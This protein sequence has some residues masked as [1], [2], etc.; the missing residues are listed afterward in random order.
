MRKIKHIARKSKQGH[1]APPT[2]HQ[3]VQHAPPAHAAPQAPTA[4]MPPVKPPEPVFGAHAVTAPPEVSLQLGDGANLLFGMRPVWDAGDADS[5]P[6]FQPPTQ[7]TKQF[8]ATIPVDPAAAW[9]LPTVSL[10]TDVAD[11]LDAIRNCKVLPVKAGAASFSAPTGAMILGDADHAA[12]LAALKAALG[13]DLNVGDSY[14]L[15]STQRVVGA[16]AHPFVTSGNV[17]NRDDY[18]T[19]TAKTAFNALPVA[20]DPT[21]PSGGLTLA[22]AQA[23]LA[24][25]YQ[26]GTHFVSRLSMGDRVYQVFAFKAEQFTHVQQSMVGGRAV[27]GFGAL[28]FQYYTTPF[29]AA[30]GFGF[31]SQIGTI[32]C[33]S[34][35]PDLKKTLDAKRWVDTAYAGTDSLFIAWS[36]AN[37]QVGGA[38]FDDFDCVVPIGLELT[39]LAAL[40]AVSPDARRA[41]NFD[42]L[43]NGA[44]VQKY[45]HGM[46]I[47]FPG[48][49][50]YGWA[51]LLGAGSWLSTLATPTM[52]LNQARLSI[53]R[54]TLNNASAVK[55]LGSWSLVLDASAGGPI[56]I[57]GDEVSLFAFIIDTSTATAPPELRFKTAAALTALQLGAGEMHG[58]L[59]L[60]AS[61]SEIH[62]TLLDGFLFGAGIVDPTA[63]RG[64][65][66]LLRSVLAPPTSD[67]ALL[68]RVTGMQFAMASAQVLLSARS[69][70]Q[71]DGRALAVA[72][73]EWLATYLEPSVG[74]ESPDLDLLAMR[75]QALYLARAAGRLAPH[76][77]GVSYLTYGTY[78]DYVQA[79][80]DRANGLSDTIRGYQVRIDVQKSAE[81]AA[82]NAQE[83]NDNIKKT[84]QL[85]TDYIG[86]M[87]QNAQD[88]VSNY[89]S[90]ITQKQKEFTK[91]ITDVEAMQKLLK[92]Q[93]VVVNDAVLQFKIDFAAW[94]TEQVAKAVFTIATDIFSVASAAMVAPAAAVVAVGETFAKISRMMAIITALLKLETDISTNIKQTVQVT[95]MMSDLQG[96]VDQPSSRE[97]SEFQIKMSANIGLIPADLAADKADLTAAFGI[98]VLRGQALLTAQGKQAQLLADIYFNQQQK[99][100]NKRQVERLSRLTAGLNLGNASLPPTDAVDLLSLTGEMENQLNQVLA[101]LAGTLA[102]QDAAVQYEYLGQPSQITRF[103]LDNLK[104]VLANQ[105]AS[106]L[107]ALN[108]FNPPPQQVPDAISYTIKG[109]PVSALQ[110]G[111]IY[112][113]IIQPS[114]REFAQYAMVRVD[115]VIANIAG[116]KST[117]GGDYLIAL[118]CEGNPFE[119][120]DR[121]GSP[122]TFY[123]ASRQFGPYDYIIAN[124]ALKFGGG[125]GPFDANISKITPFSNWQVS[126]PKSDTNAGITFTGNTVDI[127]LT[128]HVT[129]L[130]MLRASTRPLFAPRAMMAFA[131]VA[132]PALLT[133]TIDQ[134]KS[135]GAALKGWDCVLNLLEGPVNEFLAAQH[136]DKFGPNGDMTV[137]IGFVQKFKGGP[138]YYANYT[139]VGVVLGE[140]L[141]QFLENNSATVQVSQV[142][143]SGYTRTGSKQVDA[144]WVPPAVPDLNDPAIAWDPKT[145]LPITGNPAPSV[146]GNVPL[147][148]VSGLVASKKTGAVTDS[149]HSVILDFAKGSFVANNMNIST[150]DA[151]LNLQISNWFST[152]AISYIVNTVDFSDTTTLKSLQPSSFKLNVLTTNS[153][154]ILLQVFI[155]T[156]GAQP[157]NITINVNEPIPDGFQNALMIN[158]KIVFQDIFVQSFNS[159]GTNIKVGAVDPGKDFTVWQAKVTTGSVSGDVDFT[160]EN[161]DRIQYR[162]NAASNSISWGIEGLTFSCSKDPSLVLGYQSTARTV[163]FQ[164]Q[165]YHDPVCSEYSC[166]P[167]GWGDW[168]DYS[169]DVMVS[170]TGSYPL[171]VGGDADLQTLQIASSPPTMNI[172]PPN[173]SPAGPCECN[174]N[175]LKLKVA[176]LL[177][178]QIPA[179]VEKQMAGIQFKAVSLFAL[180]NL[181]FPA[182]KFIKMGIAYVPG[183]LVV[184]GTF[185]TYETRN[186]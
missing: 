10:F 41:T 11:L 145:D 66:A 88:I 77:I 134:M 20:T 40:I 39:P 42:R 110:D 61:G 44:L 162:I 173:I 4:P 128:F 174:D 122:L 19:E 33:V 58:A 166:S 64:T 47:P 159:G 87:A 104:A 53:D 168:N 69:T 154:K 2:S 63:K 14:M 56:D 54:L 141:L 102:L 83:I 169:V 109:V 149:T 153:S 21:Q 105:Q 32:V 100:I 12:S 25:Y 131:A 179:A 80:V 60:T 170:M 22:Q 139:E 117:T 146:T 118:T 45:G 67:A 89:D 148:V 111:S 177:G 24:A 98:L 165:Q 180:Y 93:Q 51:S 142:I 99:E 29:S 86:A 76:G 178:K 5:T 176:N 15:V 75:M 185:G 96:G 137:N 171:T 143:K 72:Y 161:T 78:K 144:S 71:G 28:A 120:R 150:N 68:P 181:L 48:A 59:R 167:G 34:G 50:P 97:W 7:A 115:K 186:G 65:V 125:S 9:S 3:V 151:V 123:T 18:L 164:A 136:Q 129:A 157:S 43:M 37:G 130:R 135:A 8:D 6:F 26:F 30:T 91:G 108:N 79:I 140:P 116:I 124:G 62:Q 17:S 127:V 13:I 36:T 85:L 74:G 31:T 158:T 38:I 103:D 112:E 46:A 163:G 49:T 101:S 182:R 94:E 113:F 16:C 121:S 184:F 92:E 156:T 107:N 73:L 90:I 152:H 35:D 147:A 155:A 106:I 160:S 52:S 172:D 27:T 175:A 55:T 95:K 84:G 114:A 119:D 138:N 70:S 82:K 126:L 23:Y 133:D 1:S 81:Q 57:P 183:D 132:T